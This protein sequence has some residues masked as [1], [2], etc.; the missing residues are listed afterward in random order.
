MPPRRKK[1]PARQRR[2]RRERYASDLELNRQRQRAYARERREEAREVSA[3]AKSCGDWAT[4]SFHARFIILVLWDAR[5]RAFKGV[6]GYGLDSEVHPNHGRTPSA[7]AIYKMYRQALTDFTTIMP[8]T[9]P[10]VCDTLGRLVAGD[11]LEF[12]RD[13]YAEDGTFITDCSTLFQSVFPAGY[14]RNRLESG[15][16]EDG[17]II[18][19]VSKDCASKCDLEARELGAAALDLRSCT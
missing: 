16:G 1:G 19:V 4:M 3:Y 11:W 6:R 8:M 15:V 13:G 12:T 14:I 5:R 17:E 18:R 7:S 2:E 10:D 9:F